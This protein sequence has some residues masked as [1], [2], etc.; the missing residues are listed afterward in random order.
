MRKSDIF[1]PRDIFRFSE[2][3]SASE[4]EHYAEIATRTLQAFDS[5][6]FF[7][8]FFVRRILLIRSPIQVEN[9]LCSF[10][11]FVNFSLVQWQMVIDPLS[12]AIGFNV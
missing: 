9:C 1:D 2:L 10:F 11:E 5:Q 12:V 4:L 3:V 6:V 7:W 8:L